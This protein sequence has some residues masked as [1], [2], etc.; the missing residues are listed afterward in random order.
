M[1]QATYDDANMILRLYELRRDD[2]MREAR[3][4]F[5]SMFKQISTVEEFNRACP[6][7]SG[8]NAYFRMV[9]SYWEMVASFV[10]AG[11]LNDELFFQSGGELLLT[12]EKVKELVPALRTARKNQR[13]YHNLE[14]VAG[15]MAQYM[16]KNSAESYDTFAE[17][18][19]NMA[20]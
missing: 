10:N 20:R 2:K 1:A 11:V 8:Q 16:N 15:R 14:A 12:W 19:K 17:M 6:P 3:Q 9:T 7:G 18:V 13:L 4:W 5:T